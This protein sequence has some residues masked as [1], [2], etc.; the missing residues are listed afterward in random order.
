MGEVIPF[1]KKARS[2][3]LTKQQ[4]EQS[5]YCCICGHAAITVIKSENTFTHEPT[6]SAYCAIHGPRVPVG[7]PN[8][9]GKTTK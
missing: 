5:R 3:A 9:D 8:E 1:P 4:Q 2:T 7:N 6:E